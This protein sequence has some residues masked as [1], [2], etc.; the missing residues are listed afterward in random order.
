MC[1]G[2]VAVV[3]PRDAPGRLLLDAHFKRDAGNAAILTK[4]MVE[5]LGWLGR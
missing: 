5:Q 1:A 3:V 2:S 4:G